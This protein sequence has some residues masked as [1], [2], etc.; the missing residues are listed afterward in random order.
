MCGLSLIVMSRGFSLL[1]LTT[2]L[3]MVASHSGSFSCGAQALGAP[4]SAVAARRL[5]S[6]GT[7]AW[8]LCSMWHLPRPEIKPVSPALAGGFLYHQRS[9]QIF[10]KANQ[11]VSKGSLVA[12]RGKKNQVLHI[13]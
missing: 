8:L 5:G 4:A 12:Y 7:W 10:E 13:C 3:L 11:L 1:Q 9:S 6:C 2:L